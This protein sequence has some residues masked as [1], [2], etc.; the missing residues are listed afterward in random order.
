MAAALL[1]R[2]LPALLLVAGG[3]IAQPVAEHE[4]KA[5]F[6]FNFAVFTEWPAD[7]LAP[8]APMTLCTG[9][10]SPLAHSLAQLQDRVVNGHVLT[11]RPAAAGVRG[12][13]LLVLDKPDRERW[14]QWR[15]ELGAGT[16][17]TISDD[18]RDGAVI[19][20]AVDQN[21][22]AFEVDLAAARAARLNLSSKLL[23]L[24][25]SVQ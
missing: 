1:H 13:H 2:L 11:V 9:A 18:R 7:V 10:P 14:P 15:R 25:R 17:L 19:L 23:R 16:V 12:C 6:V 21:R 22:I 8:N 24:A 4:M 3:S 20:L 5:A